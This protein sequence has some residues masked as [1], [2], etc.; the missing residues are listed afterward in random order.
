MKILYVFMSSMCY[1]VAY[2]LVEVYLFNKIKG[3]LQFIKYFRKYLN[4]TK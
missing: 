2:R 4:V 1:Q 3:K